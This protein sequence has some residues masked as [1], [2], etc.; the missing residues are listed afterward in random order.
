M[1]KR[2]C[3]FRSAIW[4]LDA[5]RHRDGRGG[6]Y[7]RLRTI[8]GV[9]RDSLAPQRLNMA[10]VGFFAAVALTLAAVGLYGVLAH[11]VAQRGRE[12]GVRIALGAQR[13]NVLGL[14]VGNGM[15]L[16]LIGIVVGMVGATALMRVMRSLLFDASPLDSVTFVSVPVV[17]SV[18]AL[19]ACW[20]PAQRPARVDSIEA[21]RAE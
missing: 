15:R 17:L 18:V 20:L 1:N 14:V 2:I 19:L 21:L 7:G 4:D 11:S 3:H 16:V 12:I 6:H 10:M 13:H 5:S 8:E 9:R